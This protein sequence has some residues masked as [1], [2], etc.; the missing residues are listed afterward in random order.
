MSGHMDLYSFEIIA[1]KIPELLTISAFWLVVWLLPAAGLVCLVCVQ[2][3]TYALEVQDHKTSRLKYPKKSWLEYS[4][5]S[6]SL[7]GNHA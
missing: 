3:Y 5:F 7:S 1:K 6:N 2:K 4:P